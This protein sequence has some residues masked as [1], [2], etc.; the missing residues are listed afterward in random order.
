MLWR[1]VAR[2]LA[3]VASPAEVLARGRSA[4]LFRA[5]M[6]A[7]EARSDDVFIVTFPKSGTTLVQMLLHQLTSDGRDSFEHITDRIPFFEAEI[8]QRGGRFDELPSP[9]IF[10]THLRLDQ[11]PRGARYVYV[12]RHPKDVLVSYYHHARLIDRYDGSMDDFGALFLAGRAGTV[13]SWFDHVERALAYESGQ[14]LF[15][16]Y[17]ELR[18]DL[19]GVARRMAGFCGLPLDERELPRIVANCSIE[20]M[21]ELEAKFDPRTASRHPGRFIREGRIGGWKDAGLR[22]HQ[23]AAID[24]KLAHLSRTAAPA[25]EGARDLLRSLS[26]PEAG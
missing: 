18:R 24:D 12:A 1:Q 14:V 5:G 26:A 17:E 2:L 21:R 11:L 3:A 16:S 15:L 9:R 20:R 13:G 8:R 4:A 25:C 6:A 23:A 22:A 19:A 10:K 7:F